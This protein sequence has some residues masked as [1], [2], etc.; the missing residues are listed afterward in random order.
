MSY[1]LYVYFYT[2]EGSEGDDRDDSEERTKSALE[3]SR[4]GSEPA[5]DLL[6]LVRK[7]ESDEGTR[8]KRTKYFVL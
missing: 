4:P 8:L 6:D 1:H 5:G 7:D 3:T 2:G